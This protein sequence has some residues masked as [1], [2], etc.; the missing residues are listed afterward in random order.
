MNTQIII[1]DIKSASE[2]GV[3]SREII[4]K[5]LQLRR[6]STADERRSRF[7]PEEKKTTMMKNCWLQ[8]RCE[9]RTL[10]AHMSIQSHQR[11]VR[12]DTLAV[13]LNASRNSRCAILALALRADY[14]SFASLVSLYSHLMPSRIAYIRAGQ[15]WLIERAFFF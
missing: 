4:G 3:G 6:R 12:A 1:I 10:V 8:K 15:G 5:G 2:D 14:G 9:E 13:C 7:R 11:T